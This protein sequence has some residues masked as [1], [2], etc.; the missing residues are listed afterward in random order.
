MAKRM[1]ERRAMNP[2][3]NRAAQA[4]LREANR[5]SLR[6]QWHE[7]YWNHPEFRERRKHA[8]RERHYRLQAEPREG[9][10]ASDVVHA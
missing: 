1:M 7:R 5:E 9:E 6:A 8:E 2:E 3:A 4:K 10:S